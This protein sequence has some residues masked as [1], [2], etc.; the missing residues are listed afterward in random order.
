MKIKSIKLNNFRNYSDIFVEFDEN[1][2]IIHGFNAQGK[3]NLIEAIY[4]VSTLKSFRT[5]KNREIIKFGQKSFNIEC[6]FNIKNKD[7]TAKINFNDQNKYKITINDVEYKSKNQVRGKLKTVIFCPDDLYLIKDSAESRRSFLNETLIQFRPKY[8]KLLDD[9]NKYLKQ[10]NHV[11][12]NLQERP[13]MVVLIDDYNIKIA[14]IGAEIAFI[15]ANFLKLLSIETKNIYSEISGNVENLD[16]N[17]ITKLS[18]PSLSIDQNK[19][20]Y[21]KLL[22]IYKVSEKSAKNALIGIH[23]DDLLFQIDSKNAREYASQ[24]QIRSIVLSLKLGVREMFF[25]DTGSHAI[26]ILD[27]VL[28]ELDKNRQDFVINKINDGQVMITTPYFDKINLLGKLIS[29]ENGQIGE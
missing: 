24:G 27:D 26:L 12:K 3:T 13:T 19:E 22:E 11:L 2:N 1:N 23:K 20:E 21:L 29:V 6:V 8:S 15:R 18:D 5:S 14:E 16:V 10:K 4:F 7:Y 25:K 17:Y 9:Y 28:S